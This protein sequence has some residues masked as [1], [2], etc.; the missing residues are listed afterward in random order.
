MKTIYKVLIWSKDI[1]FY[2][3]SNYIFL[4]FL[5]STFYSSYPPPSIVALFPVNDSLC[6]KVL[7]VCH[8]KVFGRNGEIYARSASSGEKWSDSFP[9]R[10]HFLTQTISAEKSEAVSCLNYA[11]IILYLRNQ[12]YMYLLLFTFIKVFSFYLIV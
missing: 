12:L 1:F 7:L 8:I 5:F 2:Y 6:L 4:Y 10:I 9:I 11:H 3:Y